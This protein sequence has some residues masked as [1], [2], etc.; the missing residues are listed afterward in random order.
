MI[1]ITSFWK[2]KRWWKETG[3]EIW[4]MI[5]NCNLKDCQIVESDLS[6][7]EFSDSRFQNCEFLKSNLQA[8]DFH[9]CELIQTK[10][11]NN[12]LNLIGARSLKVSNSK[13]SIEI[14]KS[15]N[16]EKIFKDMNLLTF[17]STD[18]DNHLA[19]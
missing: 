17:T 2:N 19:E 15:L 6:R 13:Q 7:S 12:N 11:Q 8:S 14:E 5:S 3:R 16:P 9:R 18:Q 4:K 1:G 10:F